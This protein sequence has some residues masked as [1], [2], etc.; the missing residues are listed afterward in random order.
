[1]LT[2]LESIPN[3]DWLDLL[4]PHMF[5]SPEQTRGSMDQAPLIMSR[6]SCCLLRLV[7][8]SEVS[9]VSWWL[10]LSQATIFFLHQWFSLLAACGE[11]DWLVLKVPQVHL[12]FDQSWESLRCSLSLLELLLWREAVLVFGA[13]RGLPSSHGNSM[14]SMHVASSALCSKILYLL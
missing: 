7:T 12:L 10:C 4:Q 6:I 9:Q 1:M 8:G 14:M 3:G 5:H 11:W 2:C 13:A